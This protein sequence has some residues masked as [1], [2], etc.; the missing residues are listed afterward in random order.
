[1][2][3]IKSQQTNYD[4]VASFMYFYSQVELL[5]PE[6]KTFSQLTAFIDLLHF[7]VSQSE[8]NHLENEKKFIL[9]GSREVVY[10]T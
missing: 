7:T 10:E 4:S 1:M 5:F 6:R 2:A 9:R 3:T 8:E